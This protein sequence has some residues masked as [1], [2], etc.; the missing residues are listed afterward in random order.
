MEAHD[1]IGLNQL[2]KF[3]ARRRRFLP[4]HVF[5]N[6]QKIVFHSKKLYKVFFVICLSICAHI[7][8]K[9]FQVVY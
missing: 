1:L 3:K 5:K 8:L 7:S 6:I 2:V 9:S 4:E